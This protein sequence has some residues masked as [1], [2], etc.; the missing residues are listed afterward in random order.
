MKKTSSNEAK[1]TIRDSMNTTL[2]LAIFYLFISAYLLYPITEVQAA[3]KI[4]VGDTATTSLPFF[5]TVQTARKTNGACYRNPR[6]KLAV[7][8]VPKDKSLLSEGDTGALIS[9]PDQRWKRRKLRKLARLVSLG[10]SVKKQQ[11]RGFIKS[12]VKIFKACRRMQRTGKHAIN[13]WNFSFVEPQIIF[14]DVFK[15]SSDW[16]QSDLSSDDSS[17]S[18]QLPIDNQGWPA[19]NLPW[20]GPNGGPPQKL[21]T[22]VFT[23]IANLYPSGNYT[24]VLS[25][26][27]F[28]LRLTGATPFGEYTEAGSYSVPVDNSD[29]LGLVFELSEYDLNDPLRIKLLLPGTIDDDRQPFNP[30]YLSDWNGIHLLRLMPIMATIEGSFPCS[31][32]ASVTSSNCIKEAE[33]R[34]MRSDRSQGLAKGVA[35]SYLIDLCNAL[36]VGGCWFN[37]QHAASEDFIRQMARELKQR[38]N[39]NIKI[40]IEYSNEIFNAEEQ[41]GIPQYPQHAYLAALGIANGYDADATAARRK[42]YAAVSARTFDIFREIFGRQAKKDCALS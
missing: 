4:T 20:T 8:L 3:P 35:L 6:G 34:P 15:Q 25:G 40:Y 2:K 31:N 11:R 33:D 41:D 26:S 7:F 38:L 10:K 14:K 19:V 27:N 30:S 1:M 23:S 9:N 36:H 16:I 32:G 18:D 17:I 29:T 22:L 37:V 28:R 12:V 39:K 24:L 5:S 21:S 13:L 42:Q